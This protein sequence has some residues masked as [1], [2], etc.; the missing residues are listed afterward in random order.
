MQVKKNNLKYINMIKKTLIL[1]VLMLGI[2]AMAQER[3]KIDGVAVV[4]GKNIV[5]NS[6]VAKFKADVEARSEG[7]IKISD[8]EMLEE[9]M[10]QKLLAHHAVIDSLIVGDSEVN[11][12]VEQN[13]QYFSQQLGSLEKVIEF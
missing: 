11:S 7:K 10:T 6:D 8:C 4:I 9:I 13:I 3:I 2:T 1:G 12:K 5:L